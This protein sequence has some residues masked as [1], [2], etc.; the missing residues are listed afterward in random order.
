VSLAFHFQKVLC[1]HERF[2]IL[3]L[4]YRKPIFLRIGN[5]LLY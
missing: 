3:S 2:V 1:N 5:N 4:I